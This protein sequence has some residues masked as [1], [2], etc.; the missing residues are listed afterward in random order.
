MT[1][2]MV[3]FD[4]GDGVFPPTITG[5]YAVAGVDPDLNGMPT[6]LASAVPPSTESTSA[7]LARVTAERDEA[8]AKASDAEH[9]RKVATERLTAERD[10]ALNLAEALRRTIADLAEERDHARSE[11]DALKALYADAVKR[12]NTQP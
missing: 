1:A 11:R 9:S 10:Y 7:A 2:P 12:L 6:A 8:R 4:N 5:E 3:P